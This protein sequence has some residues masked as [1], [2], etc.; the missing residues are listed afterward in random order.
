MSAV[1]L[2]VEHPS[3]VSRWRAGAFEVLPNAVA[4]DTVVWFGV[5]VAED[6]A[7]TWEGLNAIG[8]SDA[9]ATL[10]SIPAFAYGVSLGD[11]VEVVASAEGGLVAT[12]RVGQARARTYRVWLPDWTGD[13]PDERWRDLQVELE[14]FGCWFDVFSPRLTA[15]AVEHSVAHGVEDWL[16]RGEGSGRFEFETAG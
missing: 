6:G 16:A 7:V 10:V 4:A 8:L 12:G 5:K 2:H 3:R 11:E 14:P 15:I 13:G 1:T 9:R